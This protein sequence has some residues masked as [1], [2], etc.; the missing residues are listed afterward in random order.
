MNRVHPT[1]RP[2]AGSRWANGTATSLIAL[3]EQPGD[4]AGHC[5]AGAGYLGEIVG[6]S[7][8]GRGRR[9]VVDELR[10][11]RHELDVAAAE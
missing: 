5:L 1:M 10:S 7:I 4:I 8:H 9:Q 2:E 6:R 11:E 3:G